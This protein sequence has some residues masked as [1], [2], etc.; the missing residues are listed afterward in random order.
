MAR[1]YDEASETRRAR[2]AAET[3]SDREVFDQT[4][5]SRFR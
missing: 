4:Y 1:S 5:L 3:R 2:L